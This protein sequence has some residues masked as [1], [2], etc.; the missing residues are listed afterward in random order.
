MARYETHHGR[1]YRIPDEEDIV[2]LKPDPTLQIGVFRPEGSAPSVEPFATRQD[3]LD[4]MADSRYR[5]DERYRQTVI[6][7]IAVSEPVAQI[8]DVTPAIKTGSA[9]Q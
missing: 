4:A 8:S 1:I 2:R 9:R 5:N 7:R 6:D 3:Q